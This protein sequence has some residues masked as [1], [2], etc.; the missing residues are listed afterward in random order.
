MITHK[1][2]SNLGY[3]IPGS[4]NVQLSAHYTGYTTIATSSVVTITVSAEQP[5]TI[6]S[7]GSIPS[8]AIGRAPFAVQFWVNVSGELGSYTLRIN[9]G[10]YPNAYLNASSLKYKMLS[11]APQG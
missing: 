3:M 6:T 5:L 1:T 4:Y 2:L 7:F 11:R 10:D 9:T 8:P